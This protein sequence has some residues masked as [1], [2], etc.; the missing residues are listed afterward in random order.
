MIRKHDRKLILENGTEI[1]GYS[2]GSS[3]D[4]VLELVFNTSMVR[5]PGNCVRSVL[6]ISDGCY[7]ISCYW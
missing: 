5:I 6:Y 7:D 4:K 1:P 3:E 2:F